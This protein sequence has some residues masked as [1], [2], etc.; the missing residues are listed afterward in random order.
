M[1]GHVNGWMNG[2]VGRWVSG[3]VDKWSKKRNTSSDKRENIVHLIKMTLLDGR[4][5]LQ[6]LK[7]KRKRGESEKRKGGKD[8]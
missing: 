8:D 4:R 6:K 5:A 1:E 7:N 2:W 3:D